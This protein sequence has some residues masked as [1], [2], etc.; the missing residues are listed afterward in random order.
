[1]SRAPNEPAAQRVATA[2]PPVPT[3]IPAEPIADYHDTTFGVEMELAPAGGAK[4]MVAVPPSML[5]S[6]SRMLGAI[7]RVTDEGEVSQH[8]K[9]EKMALLTYDMGDDRKVDAGA[10]F[11]ATIEI[12]TT[13]TELINQDESKMAVAALL[14]VI[15]KA[16]RSGGKLPIS[17]YLTGSVKGVSTMEPPTKL[18]YETKAGAEGALV[19]CMGPG[20]AKPNGARGER[21]AVPGECPKDPAPRPVE[22]AT[23]AGA[24]LGTAAFSGGRCRLSAAP[25]TQEQC[26]SRSPS[27]Q[28][29]AGQP[30]SRLKLA[31]L[32]TFNTQAL[33]PTAL[34]LAA[35][36][37]PQVSVGMPVQ[38]L[39]EEA[40]PTAE[41]AVLDD[42]VRKRKS[43]SALLLRQTR[44]EGTETMMRRGWGSPGWSDFLAREE[45]SSERSEADAAE[46]SELSMRA[47]QLVGSLTGFLANFVRGEARQLVDTAHLWLRAASPPGPLSSL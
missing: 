47:W 20:P 21:F 8:G 39:L 35:D 10:I 23:L 2:A 15:L 14:E 43:Y 4:L 32:E 16:A 17:A 26:P 18:I 19:V 9:R 3:K 37:K 31:N 27:H 24:Q 33:L 38:Q 11:T 13:P 40:D 28:Q 25:R 46:L 44:S 6:G 12:I 29:A 41:T 22:R 7:Y 42:L 1:V 30:S 5:S 36:S 45:Y 34:E